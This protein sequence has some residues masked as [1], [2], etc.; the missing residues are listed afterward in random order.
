MR[1][2]ICGSTKIRISRL[3]SSDLSRLLIL[4]YPVRCRACYERFY[5][6]IP[7]A[8]NLR[9]NGKILHREERP[10]R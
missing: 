2:M 9:W 5:V 3:R 4:Q 6:G 7:L 10:A 1:C 8:L